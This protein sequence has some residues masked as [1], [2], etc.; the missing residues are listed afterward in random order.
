[1]PCQPTTQSYSHQEIHREFLAHLKLNLFKPINS[2]FIGNSCRAWNSA[3][4]LQ[5]PPSPSPGIKPPS[6]AVLLSS[7]G[8]CGGGALPTQSAAPPTCVQLGSVWPSACCCS[9]CCGAGVPVVYR[10][11]A[12]SRLWH[13]LGSAVAA[14]CPGGKGLKLELCEGLGALA[15]VC[16]AAGIWLKPEIR[17]VC[18]VNR[19][20]HMWWIVIGYFH[21][22][23]SCF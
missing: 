11:G 3:D 19:L 13:K 1:M 12:C 9:A 10:Q 15:V 21:A 6:T 4:A 14:S 22:S 23:G 5:L 17:K 16:E 2:L 18:N 20:W 7:W 8:C